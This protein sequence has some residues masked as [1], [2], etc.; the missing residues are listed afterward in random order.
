M[1]NLVRSL[2]ALRLTD[3]FPS[4]VLIVYS[5]FEKRRYMFVNSSIGVQLVIVPEQALVKDMFMLFYLEK[6]GSLGGDRT[7]I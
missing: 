1:L 3:T 7:R 4:K 2:G 5:P 6:N